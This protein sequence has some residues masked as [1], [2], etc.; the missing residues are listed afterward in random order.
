M[1]DEED[2]VVWLNPEHPQPRRG[3]REAETLVRHGS[4]IREKLKGQPDEAVL[5]LAFRHAA[6]TLPLFAMSDIWWLPTYLKA[7]APGATP[8]LVMYTHYPIVGF[9]S[10]LVADAAVSGSDTQAFDLAADLTQVIAAANGAMLDAR[11]LHPAYHPSRASYATHF[12]QSLSL[13]IIGSDIE[14]STAGVTARYLIAKTNDALGEL[15]DGICMGAAAAS[16][17]AALEGDLAALSEGSSIM[18]T[19]IWPDPASARVESWIAYKSILDRPNTEFGFWV[20]WYEGLLQGKR[21]RP[22]AL[23]R[24]LDID[25]EIWRAGAGVV[26]RWIEKDLD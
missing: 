24:V 7:T 9:W 5:Q 3:R 11:R 4:E 6:R 15:F 26:S 22:E 8:G 2:R 14:M 17:E 1:S 18:E 10:L 21:L 19:P 16:F 13:A 12:G 23:Q 25:A 20:A